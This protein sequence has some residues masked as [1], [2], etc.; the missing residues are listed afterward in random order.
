MSG[1]LAAL[2]QSSDPLNYNQV[3]VRD[4]LESRNAGPRPEKVKNF[5]LQTLHLQGWANRIDNFTLGEGVMPVSFKIQFDQYRKKDT[6]VADFGRSAI[7]RVAPVDS[8]FYFSIN[9]I[10]STSFGDGLVFF[11]SPDNQTLGSLGG[12]L[13]L[14]NSSQL[15][16][17]K[18]IAIEF[19]TYLDFCVALTVFGYMSVK[20]WKGIRTEK[21]FKAAL[22]TSPREFS[23]RELKSATRGFSLEHG[24]WSLRYCLQSLFHFNGYHIC[25]EKIKTYPRSSKAGVWRRV[26]YFLFMGLCP[27]EVL[28]IT[29]IFWDS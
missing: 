29:H 19:D 25:A 28:F 13:G 5:L 23:Y 8:R 26:N 20:K 11:L 9:N 6:L 10:N 22:L 17:N 15:T 16:K 21:S 2:D 14:V 1:P 4:F 7:G 12:Y 24:I 3:F 27:M 18:F